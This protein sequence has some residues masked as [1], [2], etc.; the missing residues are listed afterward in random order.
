MRWLE[1]DLMF[2]RVLAQ[3]RILHLASDTASTEFE[4]YTSSWGKSGS[5]DGID[6]ENITC[7]IIS[8]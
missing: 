2:W 3:E 6:N 8:L 5:G 1:N 7:M 4:L